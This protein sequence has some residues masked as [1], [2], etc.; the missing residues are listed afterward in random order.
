MSQPSSQFSPVPGLWT[1]RGLCRALANPEAEGPDVSR[2]IVDSRQ[3]SQGDLFIALSGDPGEK[4]NPGYRSNV[5]GHDYVADA[6]GRGAIGAVVARS[7][8]GTADHLLQVQ[9]TYDGLWQLGAA[10]RQR[11]H[12][13]VV[14]LTGSS[15][16]TTAKYLIS[17]ALQAF[18]PP[19]SFNNHIGVPLALANTPADSN[20]GVY[21]IG[22]NHPGEIEPLAQMVKP[23][24]ALVLNVHSAHI[25]NFPGRDALIAEKLSI[26]NALEAK[27]NAISEDLLKLDYGYTF[28][29]EAGA[30][31]RVLELQNHNGTTTASIELFSQR[32]SARVPGGGL[33]RAKAVA[34]ALLVAKLLDAPL[35]HGLN[36][37]ES[38]VPPGRGNKQTARGITVIDESYNANPDS[39][40]ATLEEFARH[41]CS[42]R[43][44]VVLG[45]MLELGDLAEPAHLALAPVL[46]QFERVFC[47]GEGAR[48]LAQALQ[49]PWFE[50]CGEGLTAAL[51]ED[52]QAGDEVLVKGSNRVFWAHNYVAGMLAAI[53][54]SA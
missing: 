35:D 5:D 40:S 49:A 26:F 13:Q 41:P 12:G 16:K 48:G 11:M 51:L 45:E 18:T 25:E 54:D 27:D 21:E 29:T 1:W 42:G 30:D 32:L 50:Q 22:T 52:L 19:G 37:S 23:D 38:L 9:D 4:F 31:A 2:V 20:V 46:Q 36:L 8:P 15:G 10:G 39:M 47:V 7:L 43:R 53:Q 6:A 33:H 14:A 28:G 44:T 17:E 34:A 24:L 3:A